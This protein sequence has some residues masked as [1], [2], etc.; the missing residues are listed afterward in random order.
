VWCVIQIESEI[1]RRS[2]NRKLVMI[3]KRD[4]L[5]S[6]VAFLAMPGQS[7]SAHRSQNR[8]V[9]AKVPRRS[10]VPKRN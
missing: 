1:R 9:L 8:S 10:L 2:R 6:T 5:G 7:S 3:P 4:K